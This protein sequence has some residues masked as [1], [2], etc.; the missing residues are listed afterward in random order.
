MASPEAIRFAR[1]IS[2][3]DIVTPSISLS[4]EHSPHNSLHS[5]ASWSLSFYPQP[6]LNLRRRSTAGTTPAFPFINT[7]GFISYLIS[8]VAFYSSPLIRHQYALRN[9]SAPNPTVR[10]NDLVFALHAVILSTFAWSQFSPRIWGF[11]QG[12][13]SV[14]HT[15]WGI[16]IGCILSILLLTIFVD[17]QPGGGYDAQAWA[18]IDVIYGISFI[19]L[20]ITTIKYIPQVYTNYK[21]KSTVGWSI[22]QNL[23]DLLGGVLS[24]LQLVIDSSLEGDWSGI[25]GNPVKFGLGNV[26]IV[27]GMV[28]MLQHY[29]LYRK[30]RGSGK[31]LEVGDDGPDGE[32]R[33]LLDGRVV[34]WR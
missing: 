14:G 19:K 25:T 2:R 29:V 30:G 24:V 22:Y 21:C 34:D 20:L 1:A 4:T 17:S 9:P 28:F 12:T 3:L 5:T 10:L 26:T 8:T 18:W 11:S 23:M 15:I 13:E 31:E 6:L 32:R 27:F 7:L 16:A 33:R